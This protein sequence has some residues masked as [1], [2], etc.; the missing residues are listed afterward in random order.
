MARFTGNP[1]RFVGDRKKVARAGKRHNPDAVADA[2]E[3]AVEATLEPT[4]PIYVP[5]DHSVADV[6]AYLRENPDEAEYVLAAEAQG[7]ARKS[8]L[9]S[10]NG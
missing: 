1:D 3:A 5:D 4:Q 9:E 10:R 8:I 7:K 6:L 2:V